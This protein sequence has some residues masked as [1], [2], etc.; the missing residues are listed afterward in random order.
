MLSGNLRQAAI[1]IATIIMLY[2]NLVVGSGSFTETGSEGLVYYAYPTSFTPAPFTFAIWLP[3]FIGTMALAVFQALP[4]RREDTLLDQ[5]AIPYL[6]ALI[7]NTL[8]VFAPLGW[9]NL[10][11]LVLF[12]SL[13]VA[14]RLLWNANR[15]DAWLDGCVRIP[16]ALFATWAGLATTLNACQL[17]VARGGTV[18]SVGAS[19]LLVLVMTAGAWVVYRT[20]EFAILAVMVWAGF[21]IYAANKSDPVITST[22]VITSLASA[23]AAIAA[24]RGLRLRS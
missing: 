16:L 21:G 3:I 2:S 5:V 6:I 13:S 12:A 11:V 4:S 24:G 20:R 1:V 19:A 23:A 7:A 15:R 14:L 22:V 18:D 9:S 10:S 17:V 8:Q